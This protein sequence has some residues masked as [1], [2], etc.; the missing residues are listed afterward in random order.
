NVSGCSAG[1][2]Y[3]HD[4][5]APAAP[6]GLAT[7]PASRSGASTG[8]DVTG[9]AEAGSTVRFYTT[10]GCSGTAAASGTAADF[11][12]AG[13]A[14]TVAANSTTTFRATATDAAGNVSGCSA[15][16]TYVHDAVAPAAPSGLA[17]SPAS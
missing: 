16:V 14:V 3:V 5:M 13:L 7:S 1:V 8:A 17:T 6:S 10:A 4:A 15:G 11:G 12:S 9:A 2:T